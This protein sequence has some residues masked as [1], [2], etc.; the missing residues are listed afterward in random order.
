[1]EVCFSFL[2]SFFFGCVFVLLLV[3]VVLFSLTWNISIVANFCFAFSTPTCCLVVASFTPSLL[4]CWLLASFVLAPPIY[5]MSPTCYPLHIS[6]SSTY[7]YFH[8]LIYFHHHHLL[9]S[10]P[11]FKY[12][13]PTC[14]PSCL[15]TLSFKLTLLL[16]TSPLLIFPGGGA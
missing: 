13:T 4:A 10:T 11:W 2:F 6:A 1:M 3:K 15:P 8:P 9:A 12:Q 7:A 5:Y 14:L 16:G